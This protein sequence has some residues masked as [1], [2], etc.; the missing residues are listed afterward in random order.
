MRK[1]LAIFFT[2]SGDLKATKAKASD[3]KAGKAWTAA[4]PLH[5]G[6]LIKAIGVCGGLVYFPLNIFYV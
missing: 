2:G 4:Q 3:K 1:Y 6:Q 5:E